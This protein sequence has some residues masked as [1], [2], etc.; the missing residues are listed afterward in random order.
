M[1]FNFT[2]LEIILAILVISFMTTFLVLPFVNKIGES[3]NMKDTPDSRKQKQ[4]PLVRIGGLAIIFGFFTS[5]FF[6]WSLNNFSI[7]SVYQTKFFV[8]IIISSIVL[9]LLGFSI[10]VP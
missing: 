2:T 4:S 10:V 3:F 1:F 8:I 5:I 6:I 7:D 9:F